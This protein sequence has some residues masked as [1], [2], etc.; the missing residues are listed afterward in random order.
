MTKLLKDGKPMPKNWLD[1][2]LEK[3]GIKVQEEELPKD[4]V[5]GDLPEQQYPGQITRTAPLLIL[6]PGP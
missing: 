2:F 3:R 1:K 5:S 6:G 4:F